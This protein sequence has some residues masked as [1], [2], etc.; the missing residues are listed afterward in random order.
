MS[1]HRLR[2]WLIA[3]LVV[4]AIFSVAAQKLDSP[5]LGWTSFAVFLCGVALYFAWRR[6]VR[7]RVF[8]REAKTADETRA[9][10]DR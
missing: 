5:W 4:A 1:A 8:D 10:P 2:I 6:A 3:T 7:A 9:R